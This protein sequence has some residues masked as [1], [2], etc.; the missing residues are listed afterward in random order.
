ML[1]TE[2]L[3]Q[4]K[5]DINNSNLSYLVDYLI[6]IKRWSRREALD[7]TQQ[8]RNFVFLHRKYKDTTLPPS[9]DIDEVWHAHILH[10]QEYHEFCNLIFG[11]YWHHNPDANG[12]LEEYQALF[13]QN[14][15]ELYKKEFGDY[16]YDIRLIPLREL[17]ADNIKKLFKKVFKINKHKLKEIKQ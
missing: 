1:L 2:E 5:Q 14:T 8:Y 7:A 4:I 10:S 3:E 6:N 16:I 11:E 9:R 15:Q 12:S 13:D 17:I